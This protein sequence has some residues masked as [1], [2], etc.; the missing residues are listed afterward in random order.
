MA[1]VHKQKFQIEQKSE[2]IKKACISF[3]IQFTTREVNENVAFGVFMLLMERDEEFEKYHKTNNGVF[4]FSFSPF[5]L[6]N[7]GNHIC[8]MANK[9]VLPNGSERQ[10]IVFNNELISQEQLA[11]HNNYRVYIFVMPEVLC[12]SAWTN[13]VCINYK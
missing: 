6:T 3:E 8:W 5:N 4:S 10:R 7:T 1:E 9:T 2:P 13:E 12:G 11:D